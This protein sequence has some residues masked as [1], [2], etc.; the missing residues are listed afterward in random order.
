MKTL[1]GSIATRI[2]QDVES[3][4]N[5]TVTDC[6][7]VLRE[8]SSMKNVPEHFGDLRAAELARTCKWA[9]TVILHDLHFT[10][11]EDNE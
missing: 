5:V 1:R 8:Y 2:E 3:D 7:K 9:L 6:W 11:P 10:P 4:S